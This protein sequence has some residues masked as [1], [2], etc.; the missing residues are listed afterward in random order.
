MEPLGWTQHIRR[1]PRSAPFT[2]LARRRS[3]LLDSG[4]L[5]ALQRVGARHD[6]AMMKASS[7]RIRRARTH[8]R[9]EA[10]R[11]GCEG[12]EA[13]RRRLSGTTVNAASAA[14]REHR[15]TALTASGRSR[16]CRVWLVARERIEAGKESAPDS[17]GRILRRRSGHDTVGFGRQAQPS[18]YRKSQVETRALPREARRAASSPFRLELAV[19]PSC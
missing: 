9:S 10:A 4:D 3:S 8:H 11:Y 17:N 16:W 6:A 12:V 2:R 18:I 7:A 5:M 1:P 15:A 13:G 19:P 14:K